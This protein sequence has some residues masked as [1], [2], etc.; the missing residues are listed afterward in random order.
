MI[1]S[2]M[3]SVES[4]VNRIGIKAGYGTTFIHMEDEDGVATTGP[5]QNINGTVKFDVVNTRRNIAELEE[6]L[7]AHKCWSVTCHARWIG[8]ER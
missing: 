4:V 6:T 5:A 8:R 1:W 3:A 7:G 2:F